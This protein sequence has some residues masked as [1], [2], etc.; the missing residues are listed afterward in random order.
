LLADA[1]NEESAALVWVSIS[2]EF[3]GT[4]KQQL[5][6]LATQLAPVGVDLVIGGRVAHQHVP[7]A[8]NVRHMS[9]MAELAAFATARREQ[10]GR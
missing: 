3:D 4:L 7:L 9:S 1:A 2:A 8:A 5:A 10:S 6:D